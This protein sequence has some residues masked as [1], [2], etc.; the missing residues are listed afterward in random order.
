MENSDLI[1]KVI[2]P[3]ETKDFGDISI[4]VEHKEFRAHKD[5]LKLWSK[6]FK[7]MFESG[8]KE[9]NSSSINLIEES[10]ES[11]SILLGTQYDPLKYT[12]S[13]NNILNLFCLSDKYQMD[14]LKQRCEKFLT[15]C[16]FSWKLMLELKKYSPSRTLIKYFNSCLLRDCETLIFKQD[17]NILDKSLII[18]LFQ[19]Y[20]RKQKYHQIEALNT[21]INFIDVPSIIHYN[22]IPF[23]D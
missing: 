14:E 2:V 18:L 23:K 15:N 10:P 4:I 21:D 8:M 6:Y 5:L 16:H 11:F 20:I 22:N 17:F 19:S 1:K 3:W 12:I 13:V 9:S 7:T